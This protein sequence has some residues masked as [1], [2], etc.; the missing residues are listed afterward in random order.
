MICR[1]GG[2]GFCRVWGY[3]LHL[4][5]RV[6]CWASYAVGESVG[7]HFSHVM[8]D[9]VRKSRKSSILQ[10]LATNFVKETICYMCAVATWMTGAWMDDEC[11]G[12]KQRQRKKQQRQELAVIAQKLLASVSLTEHVRSI[13]VL[14][15]SCGVATHAEASSRETGHQFRKSRVGKPGQEAL[16]VACL[17]HR[18]H[19]SS[20]LGFICRI[21]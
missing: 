18:P 13:P 17:T 6:G 14:N 3:F 5:E 19:S 8:S 1:Q 7:P 15:Y 12:D 10:I 11:A 4:R 21:L 2:S 16:R 9:I 20:F